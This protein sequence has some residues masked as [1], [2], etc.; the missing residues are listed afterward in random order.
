ME[1]KEAFSRFEELFWSVTRNMGH[2]WSKIFEQHLPGSQSY[3][4]FMLERKGPLRMSELADALHLTAGAVTTASDKLIEQGYIQRKRDEVDRRVVYLEITEKGRE[5]MQQ[6]R[7]EGRKTMKTVF[8][9]LSETDLQQ[10]TANFEQ[11]AANIDLLRKE[12]M[13]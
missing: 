13:A 2:M 1:N 11:A 12:G 6:L 3:L 10:M 8:G 5:T 7:N 4:I 9:H